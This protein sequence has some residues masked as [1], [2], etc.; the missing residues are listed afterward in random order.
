MA[1]SSQQPPP[2]SLAPNWSHLCLGLICFSSSW[3]KE[4]DWDSFP[5][6]KL[7][8]TSLFSL[9][10]GSPSPPRVGL[11]RRPCAGPRACAQDIPRP[12][13]GNHRCGWHPEPDRAS[14]KAKAEEAGSGSRPAGATCRTRGDCKLPGRTPVWAG[15]AG[16]GLDHGR[17]PSV[18]PFTPYRLVL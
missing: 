2:A 15:G 14:E 4:L 5:L 8:L 9:A 12:A 16:D 1:K 18:M 7:S 11:N 17:V 13:E 3:E 6:E 10:Q